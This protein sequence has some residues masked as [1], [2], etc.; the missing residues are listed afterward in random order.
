MPQFL[1]TIQFPDNYEPSLEDEAMV[2][3][4]YALSEEMDAA[5]ITRFAGG[6]H[7]AHNAKTLRKQPN[8]EVIITDGPYLEA[9]EHIG[10]FSIVEVADIAQRSTPGRKRRG[11]LVA[12][13]GLLLVGLRADPARNDCART[14]A[15]VGRRR[16][17][18]RVAGIDC[19]MSQR[20]ASNLIPIMVSNDRPT[21][22]DR[23]A[24]ELIMA[25][26]DVLHSK[27]ECI[28]ADLSIAPSMPLAVLR[29]TIHYR[30][31]T[32]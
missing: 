20:R 22:K 21:C 11:R 10:G 6:L 9:K 29:R 14:S 25:R 32:E 5:G 2:R 8:G 17:T 19:R 4:V 13:S 15:K 1:V 30:L 12:G 3:D 16:E 27:A 28:A 23:H 18:L 24:A 26:R 31:L 7:P